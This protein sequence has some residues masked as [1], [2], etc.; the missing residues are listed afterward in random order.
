MMN[1]NSVS[2]NLPVYN[3]E[4]V[5]RLCL[6]SIFRQ[7][8]SIQEIVMVDNHSTDKTVQVIEN[9]KKRNKRIPI[10]IT[11]RDKTYRVADSFNLGAKLAK[12]AY[13]V[14]MHSDCVL[15]TKNELKKLMEPFIKDPSVDLS[16]PYVVLPKYIWNKYNFWQKY[17]FANMVDVKVASGNGQF[18]CIKREIFLKI[19][20]YDVKNFGGRDVI[21]GE[22]ADLHTRLRKSGKI[23]LSN[24]LVIHAHYIGKNFSFINIL[25]SKKVNARSYGRFV[26]IHTTSLSLVTLMIFL[27]KF[28]LALLP[29]IPYLW[30]IGI[31]LLVIYSFYYSR[32]L[33]FDVSSLRDPKIILVPF[34]NIFLVYFDMFWM[35]EAFFHKKK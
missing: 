6:E 25:K 13:I 5:I 30:Y 35:I 20:G 12:G 11:K 15:P 28:A 26:R 19:G 24:A 31:P 23:V 2:I 17:L 8:Y 32:K 9:F 7:D 14:N 18:E 4:T 34:I 21:G 10:Y 1:T 16:A 33:F 22:D 27:S 29:F 3:S